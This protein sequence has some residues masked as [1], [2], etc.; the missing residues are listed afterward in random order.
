VPEAP[1]TSASGQ[2]IRMVLVDDRANIGDYL[3]S[4]EGEKVIVQTL[5]R[6]SL[7]VRQVLGG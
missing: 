7:A 2:P 5:R 1:R 4:S 3:A 6:N